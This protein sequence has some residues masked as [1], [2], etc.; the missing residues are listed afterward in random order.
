[1]K[2]CLIIILFHII[3]SRIIYQCAHYLNMPDQC[4]NKRTDLYNNIL[5][6]LW[7]CPMNKYCQ[8]LDKN[9]LEKNSIGVCMYNYK[10]LYSGDACTKDSECAS[11][12]CENNKCKGFKENEYCTPGLFQ[13]EDNLICK[14][15][16]ERLPYDEEKNVFKCKKIGELNEPCE[17]SDECDVE[18]V[19]GDK[20]SFDV[21]NLMKQYGINDIMKLNES[22][23]LQEYLTYKNSSKKICINRASLENGIPSSE[24]MAC[25]S[26]D[27]INLELFENYTE[28]I[29]VSKNE[30]IKKCDKSQICTISI[31]LG[32]KNNKTN[33]SQ[34][35]LISS[36]GNPF[37]PLDQ[38]EK[39]WKNYLNIFDE[40][41]HVSQS[42][43]I[44]KKKL[45]HFPVYKYTFNE[46]EVSQSFWSYKLWNHYIEAD[47]CTKDFFFLKNI[48]NII[49]YNYLYLIFILLFLF[50]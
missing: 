35:C 42:N 26:G 46:F 3:K 47:I 32:I 12:N 18:L 25:K 41:Y 2:K 27:T 14:Q 24:P 29:C 15:D 37:C 7:Q 44:I 43:I 38:K 20:Y 49:K 50:F 48:D 40:Y 4:M 28:S 1:M 39:A 5:I 17:N 13:C 45:Y 8:I 34:E 31:N 30:I 16:K 36:L 11:L 19:C 6:D 23:T 9:N 21:D 22:I 33:I 10:K